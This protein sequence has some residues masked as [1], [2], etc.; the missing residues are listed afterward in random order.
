MYAL[1]LHSSSSLITFK[2]HLLVISLS[3][4]FC[5][6]SNPISVISNLKR[7]KITEKAFVTPSEKRQQEH[8]DPMKKKLIFIVKYISYI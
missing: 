6:E 3:D 5:F 7:V 1:R 8:F 4:N 2:F